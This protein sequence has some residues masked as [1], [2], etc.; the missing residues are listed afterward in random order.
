MISM[1][2]GLREKKVCGC[3]GAS[4]VTIATKFSFQ[5]Y[6][7]SDALSSTCM[8][9][10]LYIIPSLYSNHNGLNYQVV[11]FQNQLNEWPLFR[12]VSV[13]GKAQ[14]HFTGFTVHIEEVKEID[15]SA[16]D[17][18]TGKPLFRDHSLK[19][20]P[21]YAVGSEKYDYDCTVPRDVC[22]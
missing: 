18:I 2:K 1:L 22:R 5:F 8:S 14:A 4:I 17:T 7:S 15:I 9:L 13:I 10:N 12:Q 11:L 3:H 16:H 19:R 20:P 21:W 6:Y